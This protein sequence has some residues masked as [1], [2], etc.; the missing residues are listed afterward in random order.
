MYAVNGFLFFFLQTYNKKTEQIHCPVKVNV[1][2]FYLVIIVLLL[3]NLY[4]D[5]MFRL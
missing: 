2:V 4:P 3:K 5:I 1:E